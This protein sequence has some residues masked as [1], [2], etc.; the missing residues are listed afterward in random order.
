MSIRRL[1]KTE[2]VVALGLVA[3]FGISCLVVGIAL[4]AHG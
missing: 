4:V 2:T 1:T 3:V